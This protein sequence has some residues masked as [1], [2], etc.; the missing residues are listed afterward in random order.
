[1]LGTTIADNTN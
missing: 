1:M